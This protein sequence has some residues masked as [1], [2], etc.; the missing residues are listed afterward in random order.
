[1]K[2][3]IK[4]TLI[5]FAALVL[6]CIGLAALSSTMPRNQTAT[7]PTAAVATRAPAPTDTPKTTVAPAP[8]AVPIASDAQEVAEY[9]RSMALHMTTIS[10]AL[11][12]LGKLSEVPRLADP[13][14]KIDMA[15]ALATLRAEN[16][17][18]QQMTPPESMRAVHTEVL[19][20]T[21]DFDAMTYRY[22][23][24]IDT[25]DAGQIRAAITL[26]QSGTQHI[27]RAHE[28]LKAK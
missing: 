20:A 22:A 10:S 24:G 21:A 13:N 19:A 14:W 15:I 2:K 1:M 7:A 9:S 25:M 16:E 17:A 12:S 18:V 5:A 6:S 8:T 4:I 27:T 26:M 3:L 23:A 11:A 28:L